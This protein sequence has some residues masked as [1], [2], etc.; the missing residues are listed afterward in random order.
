MDHRGG[1]AA[2]FQV[3]T[4]IGPDILQ[5]WCCAA[6]SLIRALVMTALEDERRGEPELPLTPHALSVAP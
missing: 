4:A 2:G 3:I 5:R 1:K 6:R